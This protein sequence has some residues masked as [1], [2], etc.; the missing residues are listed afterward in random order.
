M[1]MLAVEGGKPVRETPIVAR[2][3]VYSEEVLQAVA[4]VLK[5]GVLT[6]QHGMTRSTL[7][8]QGMMHRLTWR[9]SYHPSW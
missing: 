8:K 9:S 3:V 2:P 5:S 7:L 4:D 6:A 1:P